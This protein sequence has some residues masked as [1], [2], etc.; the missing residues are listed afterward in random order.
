MSIL[1]FIAIHIF[2]NFDF[3]TLN[4][5][6][7]QYIGFYVLGG[8]CSL[9]PPPCSY[10]HEVGLVHMALL[11]FAYRLYIDPTKCKKKHAVIKY[12]VG[13]CEYVTHS[14]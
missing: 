7:W 13:R 4:F 8:Y 10:G 9:L 14:V 12:I 11:K 1:R 5:L 2:I 6:G 3:Y